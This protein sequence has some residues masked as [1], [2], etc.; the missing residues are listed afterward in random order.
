VDTADQLAFRRKDE[1][2]IELGSCHS[3]AA[4][5]VTIDI[6]ASPIGSARAGVYKDAVI[7][8]LSTV[9][10]VV[11]PNEA[12]RSRPRFNNVELRL[13]GRETQTIGAA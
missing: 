2:A 3:P 8:Q 12:V 11:D 10:Y 1:N 4:P 13:V 5:Q 7:D 9:D 6:R